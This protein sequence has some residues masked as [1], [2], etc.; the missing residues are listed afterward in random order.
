MKKQK[1]VRGFQESL[2]KC[3]AVCPLMVVWAE[4]KEIH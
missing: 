2:K 4:D 1:F 3:E